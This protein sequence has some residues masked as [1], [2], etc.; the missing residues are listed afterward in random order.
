MATVRMGLGSGSASSDSPATNRGAKKER[1]KDGTCVA[2]HCHGSNIKGQ[3]K[4]QWEKGLPARGG[5]DRDAAS[6]VAGLGS[7]AT[8]RRKKG[9]GR[10]KSSMK[11]DRRKRKILK[12]KIKRMA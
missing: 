4:I 9:E 7:M 10:G 8:K 5:D 11:I 6:M 12:K 3:R 2:P 1:K